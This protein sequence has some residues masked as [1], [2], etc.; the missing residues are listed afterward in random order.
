MRK[1]Q[2]LMA[3]AF[4]ATLSFSANAVPN[5]A[6]DIT[7]IHSLV[8]QV[9]AGVGTPDLL[10]QSGASPHNYS[11]SPSEAQALQEADLVF[12]VGE[13]LTPWLERSL[14]NLSPDSRKVELLEAMGTTTYTF[15]EGATFD[16][17]DDLHDGEEKENEHNEGHHHEHSGTD[18][19]AW[20]DPNNGKVWLDVIAAALAEEDPENAAQYLENSA[21]R[22]ADIDAAVSRIEITVAQ[23]KNKQFIVFHDA[24][25]YFEKRF[26]IPAVG[27]I[28]IGDAS[29]PSP[30]R[31]AEIRKVVT[32]LNVSC[33]FTEP[34]YNPGIVKAV[35][36][37]TGVNTSGVIDPLGSGLAT[38]VNLYPDLL[39]EIADGLQSCLGEK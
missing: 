25:Q 27:A 12:W 30:A 11:L 8:S 13:G 23:L 36:G 5:V 24:Y 35:F 38:G 34:Q 9:M 31:I 20:L 4:I 22:K 39:I 32:D 10:V 15:R 3:T 19:H 17:H 6:T 28:S 2:K 7:P 29:K 21:T 37:G 14:D 18:P 33:V 26:G 16:T 1:R